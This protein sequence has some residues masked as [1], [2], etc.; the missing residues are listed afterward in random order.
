[1]SLLSTPAATPILT[2]Q[3]YTGGRAEGEMVDQIDIAIRHLLTRPNHQSPY[4]Y[5]FEWMIDEKPNLNYSVELTIR[6]T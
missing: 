4:R 3:V 6:G 5:V 2:E 1:M